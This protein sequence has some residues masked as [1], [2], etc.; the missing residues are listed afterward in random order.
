MAFCTWF[1]EKPR[2]NSIASGVL[3]THK[4]QK[5]L[6]EYDPTLREF[7]HVNNKRYA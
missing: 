7:F 2:L 1:Y 4:K 3:F 5:E 6:V